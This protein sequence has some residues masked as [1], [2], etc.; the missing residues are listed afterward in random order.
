MKKTFITLST[1]CIIITGISAF[2]QE[3][4]KDRIIIKYRS[5]KSDVSKSIKHGKLVKKFKKSGLL[6][7]KLNKGKKVRETISE[8]RKN[9]DIILAEP[10]YKLKA[11]IIPNDPYFNDLWGV[12]RINAPE[13]WPI[14]DGSRN[15]I[16]AVIDTGVDYNHPDLAQNIWI[17]RGE[18]PNNGIDDD[19]N[20]YIDDYY[21]WDF[22][23]NDSE[24]DDVYGHG[25]HCAGTIGA[26]G[27]NSTGVIGISPV[28]SIMSL[29]FLGDD[30]GGWTSDAVRAIEY[31]IDKGAH[32]LSNSWGGGG[33]SLA[34]ETAIQTAGMNGITFVVAAGN[35]DANIDQY[36][37]Y[38][39]NYNSS[40]IISVGASTQSDSKAY[41]S[42]YGKNNV[43]IF[44]PGVDILSTFPGYSYKSWQGTSMACPHVSG[45]AA[46]MLSEN[47]GLTPDLI[48]EIMMRNSDKVSYM[49]NLSVSG[50]IVNAENAVLESVPGPSIKIASI[51]LKDDNDNGIGEPGETVELS[52]EI[53]NNG[54]PMVGAMAILRT[55]EDNIEVVNSTTQYPNTLPGGHSINT[56][57]L[58]LK[59]LSASELKETGLTL[60]IYSNS[61]SYEKSLPVNI[62]TGSGS[63]ILIVDDDGGS[64]REIAL[65]ESIA[66]LGYNSITALSTSAISNLQKGL[67]PDAVIWT[68][69][70]VTGEALTLEEIRAI[71]SYID[72]GGSF[73]L[74]GEG[75]ADQLSGDSFLTEKLRCSVNSLNQPPAIQEG[76]DILS[77]LDFVLPSYAVKRD[78]IKGYSSGKL[79]AY[80]SGYSTGGTIVYAPS[81]TGKGSSVSISFDISDLNEVYIDLILEKIIQRILLPEIKS[82]TPL[83]SAVDIKWNK[84][85]NAGSVDIKITTNTGF[86]LIRNFE[87][88][89]A[90]I[91][92]LENGLEHT[93]YIRS[94]CESGIISEW[95]RGISFTPAEE[96]GS[97]LI[98][99]SNLRYSAVSEGV[100]INWDKS[101]DSRVL[102]YVVETEIS[103]ANFSVIFT[104]N[105]TALLRRSA[106]ST[107]NSGTTLVYPV[108]I[109]G[110]TG[111]PAVIKWEYSDIYPPED[112]TGIEVLQ[113]GYNEIEIKWIP[114]SSNDVSSYMVDISSEDFETS[115]STDAVNSVKVSRISTGGNY[116]IK[117]RVIDTA[118][119][120]STGST[121]QWGENGTS[122][123]QGGLCGCF[124]NE[125]EGFKSASAGNMAI[126]FI[127]N[128]I[129]ISFGVL[130]RFIKRFFQ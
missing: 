80:D 12:K 109:N 95:S 107:Y 61:G 70:K 111:I 45:T 21:G 113:T 96:E 59:V 37:S 65:K 90:V 60:D 101:T 48:R 114:S 40:N 116:L 120:I 72:S 122:K 104:E 63:I 52:I 11:N 51:S 6:L 43:D 54:I 105:S 84:P 121:V 76:T 5:G 10:D 87:D 24:P 30:G 62:F 14:N 26:V 77:N 93:A 49:E 125:S 106:L 108:D 71:E 56:D 86:E 25:T 22:A 123:N 19:S 79:I 118:G 38:P 36:T 68:T 75:W 67:V 129:I 112:V 88:R 83:D 92:G 50:G 18:I 81:E 100:T 69:G 31:A 41:F 117:I 32:V 27:Y 57:P 39:S 15:I 97:P 94:R 91:T 8:L 102:S 74:T 46:L 115:A 58:T 99:V 29:K 85:L 44:A 53:V 7:L 126:S 1:F 66:K 35:E 82:I 55:N 28:V 47:P 3:Y 98:P 34:L 4:A 127:L 73:I 20:G 130:F 89:H 110:D 124:V 64:F 119:N 16:V 23:Y 128:F 103:S 33:Y 2:S 13:A 78:V 9:P 17:N 42:N